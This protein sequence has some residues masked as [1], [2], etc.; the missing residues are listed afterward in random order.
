MTLV[1]GYLGLDKGDLAKVVGMV[2]A[3]EATGRGIA[4][5]NSIKAIDSPDGQG[6]RLQPLTRWGVEVWIPEGIQLIVEDDFVNPSIDDPSGTPA[7]DAVG[8]AANALRFFPVA[9]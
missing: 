1:E 6:I 5:Q 7:V 8:I 2:V 3:S 9:E 4:F